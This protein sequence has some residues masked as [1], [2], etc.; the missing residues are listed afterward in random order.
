MLFRHRL[1]LTFAI[2]SSLASLLLLTWLLLSII[3]FKTAEKDLIAQKTVHARTLLA[4]VLATL[5]DDFAASGQPGTS[6]QRMVDLLSM[7]KDFAGMTVLAADGRVVFSQD[8]KRG[9]DQKLRATRISGAEGCVIAEGGM[10]LLSYAP[11]RISAVPVGA[12]RLALSLGDVHARL[13]RSR[14]LFLG[15]F[16]LDFVLLLGLGGYILRR[17]VV[18]PLERLLAATQRI[19]AG[20]YSH[21]VT[22][23]GR[24]EI[25]GLAESFNSMQATLQ[26]RQEE[27]EQYVHSLEEANRALQEARQES[28]RSEKMASIGLLAAGMAH[29]I[30]TPLAA[31]IGY[32]GVLTDELAHDDE[33]SDYLRRISR[34]AERIDRLVR[35]LLDYARPGRGEV[36]AVE[37]EPFLAD[38]LGMLAGQG[39]FKKLQL[40]TEIEQGLPPL[41]LDR[42]K[43]MQVLVNLII[44]ARDAMPSGGELRVRAAAAGDWVLLA[45]GDTGEGIPAENREKIFEPFFT[46]KEP[47]QGTGLGLA[48]T[49]RLVES[50]GGSIG[51]ESAPR[52]GATFTVRLP[53]AERGCPEGNG[54]QDP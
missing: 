29:E 36:A 31:I 8:D 53:L 1:N 45:I 49:A 54:D 5:P 6:L 44:N 42:H 14:T 34:E 18:F 50:F 40:V 41:C 13:N 48:I 7:E 28:I 10:T 37:L 27:V 3:S 2:L 4:T 47:G 20:D 38:L 32:T 39:V 12:A 22:A 33:K 43:L 11:I 23:M 51:V 9:I 46:T 15:Y 30:G 35:D 21:P 24:A 25:A 17:I 19:S 16:I 26:A 52:E